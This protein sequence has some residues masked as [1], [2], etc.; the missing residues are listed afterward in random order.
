MILSVP[1]SK[2]NCAQFNLF[3]EIGD[4]NGIS[5]PPTSSKQMSDVHK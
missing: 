4:Y 3:K 5:T 2:Q 1:N